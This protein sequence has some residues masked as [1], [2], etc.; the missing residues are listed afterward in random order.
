M[1]WHFLT[2]LAPLRAPCDGGKPFISS[3]YMVVL[4][5]SCHLHLSS[6]VGRLEYAL[7]SAYVVSVRRRNASLY[8]GPGYPNKTPG[9]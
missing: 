5:C 6:M 8:V 9:E 2:S 7:M 4:K 1:H 3:Q